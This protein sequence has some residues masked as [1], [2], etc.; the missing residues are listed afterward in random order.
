[1]QIGAVGAVGGGVSSSVVAPPV[2]PTAAASVPAPAPARSIASN[3]PF[4]NPAIAQIAAR[5][6]VS[7]TDQVLHGDAGLLVQSYGAV[8][9]LTGPVA[10]AAAYGLPLAPAVPAV[11]PITAYPKVQP[12]AGFSTSSGS[13]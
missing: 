4:L 10:A 2:E 9:L 8:A 5:A 13:R 6:A 7:P 1:M 12:P 3:P 11:A